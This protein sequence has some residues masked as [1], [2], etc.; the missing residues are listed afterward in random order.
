MTD[1]DVR[2]LVRQAAQA[3]GLGKQTALDALSD[4]VNQVLPPPPSDM[5]QTVSGWVY[6]L[7]VAGIASGRGPEDGIHWSELMAEA[8]QAIAFFRQREER[9]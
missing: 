2:G 1:I 9:P 7:I 5:P 3:A 6:R 8:R 4:A